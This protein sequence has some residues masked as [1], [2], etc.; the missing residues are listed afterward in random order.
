[1]T[2]THVSPGQQSR[3]QGEED[4]Q[5]KLQELLEKLHLECD[6]LLSIEQ[7]IHN[8]LSSKLTPE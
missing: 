6:K 8:H 5:A 1:M 7:M 2:D 4:A 3:K